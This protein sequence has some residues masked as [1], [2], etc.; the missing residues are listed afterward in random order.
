MNAEITKKQEMVWIYI[1][2]F[3]AARSELAGIYPFAVAIF[4]GAYLAGCGSWGLYG[5][6]LFGIASTFSLNGMVKY[7]IILL[8]ITV[9]ISIVSSGNKRNNPLTMACMSGGITMLTSFIWNALPT[10]GLNVTFWNPLRDQMFQ[11]SS[12]AGH[13]GRIGAWLSDP[14]AWYMPILEGVI[15][16]CFILILEQAL[17]VIRNKEDIMKSENLLSTLSLMAIVLWGI[18][19]Q[20][21]FY[22]TALQGVICYLL[23]FMS[24]RYG[25]A[26]GTSVGTV[27]GV[28]LA[29]RTQQ[30]EWVA[31]CVILSLAAAFLGEWSR[32]LETLGFLAVIGFLGF[33]YYPELLEVQALRGLLSA[34]VLFICTPK[35]YLLKYSMAG[36]ES[37][38][39]LVSSEVQ[40][41]TRLRLQDF[42]EV[43]TK[44]GRS[45]GEPAYALDN[46]G[47]ALR[48]PTFARQMGEIGESLQE[49]SV[50]MYTP[51]AVNQ[52]QESIVIHRLERQNVRVKHLVMLK[53]MYGKKEI[54][55]SA[56]TIRGRVMTAK[57]AAQ[58]ISEALGCDYRVAP[59]SRMLINREYDVVMFEEDTHY[60]YL[61]GAR[62]ITKEGQQISGDNFSQME[63][64]NGQLLMILAD[65]MGSGEE[66]SRQSEQ[67]VDLLEEM[68]EA[69][70]KKESAIEILNEL[71]AMQGQG[72][73]FATLDLC[74]VDLYSGVGEFLKMGASTT[75]IKRGQW[76]ESIQSTTLPV[77]IQEHTDIDAIQ[78]KFYHGDMIIMVSDG[79]LDGILF[80]NKE[81]CLKEML[82][83]IDAKNPQEMADE[84]IDR[85]LKM[86]GRGMRDDASVLVL[87]IWKK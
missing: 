22:F 87:G 63:L 64:K 81:E 80:D 5:T 43:F 46:D 71:I 29:L 85:I 60:R 78:K 30:V 48:Y 86:N 21:A 27:C 52:Q 45:F 13:A 40:K 58:I 61:T 19:L 84:I 34:C 75:F 10:E 82:L 15:V 70:F 73:R 68:L 62:R 9:G 11:E 69:G 35:S 7:G 17:Q 3:L 33:F 42:A 32:L 76:I 24:Y 57:E 79:V 66:A 54:Y 37:D 38:T 14:F 77:G 67:L 49:F 47:Q 16:T 72:E 20:V 83:E 65:G 59:S 23:L 31:I 28:I 12:A 2:T 44:I 55:L 41:M 6:I 39:E 74:M 1:L 25:V 36:P 4:V 8:L 53:G 56:R 50:G 26:Y 51:V 18:P